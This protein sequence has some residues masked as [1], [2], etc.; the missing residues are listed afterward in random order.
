MSGP[1]PATDARPDVP[2]GPR[3]FRRGWRAIEWKIL[4]GIVLVLVGAIVVVSA[5]VDEDLFEPIVA[6]AASVRGILRTHGYLG[7]IGL[8]Y[9]EE[10]GIPVP[11]PGDVFVLYVGA[12]APKQPLQWLAAFAGVIVAV[13]LGSSNLY[14]IS[15]NFGRK[16][17]EGR[18]GRVLHITPRRMAKAEGWFAR[19]GIWAIIFGRHIPGFRV[20]ITVGAGLFRVP[21]RRFAVGVV[22]STVL[23]A[24]FFMYMGLRFGA[25]IEAFMLLHRETYWLIPVVV[26]VLLLT[27]ILTGRTQE[28][29]GQ[30]PPD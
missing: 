11:A 14:L 18:I 6:G 9:V 24:G 25:R 29:P 12:H 23:W 10:S 28:V 17:I 1:D 27:R 4:A 19:W 22:I 3:H 8:L 15:R 21:Y 5:L 13:L 30:A 26:V 16:L 2:R 20:P 7:A